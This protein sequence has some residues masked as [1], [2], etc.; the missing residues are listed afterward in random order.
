M[1]NV[2]ERLADSA[3]DFGVQAAYGDP[4]YWRECYGYWVCGSPNGTE[5]GSDDYRKPD[6]AKAR[7]LL[8]G[9]A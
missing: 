5:I 7:A 4:K 8:K 2:V 1:T 3:K 6:L 9:A